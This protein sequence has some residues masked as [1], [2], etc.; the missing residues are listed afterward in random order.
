MQPCH[1]AADRSGELVEFR[2]DTVAALETVVVQERL[3][4]RREVVRMAEPLDRHDLVA[5]VHAG[6][7]QAGVDPPPVDEH[8][9]GP[10]LTMVAALLHAVQIEVVA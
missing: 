4:Q 7:R 1:W 9:T 5:V 6:E 8:G 3:L 10:A 2:V